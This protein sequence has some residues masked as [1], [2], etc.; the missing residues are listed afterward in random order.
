[1]NRLVPGG[2]FG[3]FRHAPAYCH[4]FLLRGCPI[5]F[6]RDSLAGDCG[7]HSLENIVQRHTNSRVAIFTC[8]HDDCQINVWHDEQSLPPLCQWLR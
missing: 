2:P 4:P 7:D 1:M 8:R 5:L 3:K 6:F